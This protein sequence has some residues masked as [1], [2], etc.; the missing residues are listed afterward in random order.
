MR[1]ARNISDREQGCYHLASH[2]VDKTPYFKKSDK[3]RLRDWLARYA[4]FCG[5]KVCEETVMSNHFHV[6]AMV[7]RRPAEHLLPDDQELI[8]RLALV[9]SRTQ[10][11][12]FT[13][14]LKEA[15]ESDDV[16]RVK[17][18]REK[19]MAR[20]WS[21]SKF[22]QQLLSRF[23][24][25][26]NRLHERKG[27]LWRARF[28]STLVEDNESLLRV[29]AY[30]ALNP[31]RAGIVR[32][33]VE[34]RWTGYAQLAAGDKGVWERGAYILGECV[35]IENPSDLLKEYR[36]LLYIEGAEVTPGSL[37]GGKAR[38]G[39]KEEE[40]NKVLARDG[41]LT[42]TEMLRVR[43]RYFK[44]GMVIG[45]REFVE[46][47]IERYSEYQGRKRKSRPVK[48]KGGC[49]DGMYVFRGLR[50]KIFEGKVYRQVD[51]G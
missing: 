51:G 8:R 49:W 16:G 40:V 28:S 14:E 29:A 3:E 13:E 33:P 15:R 5:V 18:I 24:Q 32:D 20:M 1:L 37:L 45:S 25:E 47:A 10:V 27:A 34:Y 17:A 41:K 42:L 11:E 9:S 19:V 26:Y 46:Q 23:A 35:G 44:D 6:L 36:K 7:P 38:P 43:V 30:I 2:T 22:M 21:L 48:M 12:R 39:F 50:K 4:E 31:V